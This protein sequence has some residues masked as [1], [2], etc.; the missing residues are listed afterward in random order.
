MGITDKELLAICNF[1]NLKIE[2]ADI[3]KEKQNIPDPNNQG[4]YIEKI[5]SNHTISS[6]LDKETKALT[7]LI[8]GNQAALNDLVFRK[9]QENT[10]SQNKTIVPIYSTVQE[11]KKLIPITYEYYEKKAFGNIQGEFLEQWE[12]LYA[13]DTYK[14]ITDFL[15]TFAYQQNN[16]VFTF[17]NILPPN[18]ITELSD[19]AEVD[20]EVQEIILSRDFNTNELRK[21]IDGIEQ[22]VTDKDKKL[23]EE[24]VKELQ[25]YPTDNNSI[26]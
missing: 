7:S 4:K 20:V 15:D 25:L 9:I 26:F 13:A 24:K 23:Y 11:I 16:Y 12:I 10:D 21:S 6:L 3:I 17:D 19:N 22:E 2:F 5:I 1:S 8:Q 14:I 18:N